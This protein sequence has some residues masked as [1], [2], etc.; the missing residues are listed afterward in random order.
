MLSALIFSIG[1][2]APVLLVMMLGYC[3]RHRGW[4]D[5]HFVTQGSTMVF[6]VG[7]PSVLFLKTSHMD[8]AAI[9]GAFDVIVVGALATV[10][11]ILVMWKVSP[12]IAPAQNQRGVFVQGAYRSNMGIMGLA[13]VMNMYGDIALPIAAIYLSLITIL[14]NVC[15]VAVLSLSNQSALE[16]K[17]VFKHIA[18]NPLIHSLLLG[19]VASALK[20][21][22]PAIMVVS[23]EYLSDMVLPLALI[24]IGAKLD[25]KRLLRPSMI[26]FIGSAAK[27]LFTPLLALV[28]GKL[29]GLEPM[30]LGVLFLMASAPSASAS[31]AMAKQFGGDAELAADMIAVTTIFA[32]VTTAFGVFILTIIGWV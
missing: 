13:T 16:L 30:E 4:V 22:L 19:I 28:L 25:L 10:G 5:G 14:Y 23:L 9:T 26:V 31:F 15:A 21:E 24:C 18:L 1:I 8:F 29:A 27:L 3:A 20:I 6:N 17:P 11:A 7:L 32:T 12:L 2:T